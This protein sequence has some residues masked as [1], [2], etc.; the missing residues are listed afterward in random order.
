MVGFNSSQ[1]LQASWAPT[2]Q[3]EPFITYRVIA[4]SGLKLRAEPGLDYNAIK[5]LPY[6]S[7]IS[8]NFVTNVPA[9]IDGKRAPGFCVY[10][11]GRV[12]WVFDQNVEPIKNRVIFRNSQCTL[13]RIVMGIL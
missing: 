10:G 3:S 9:T 13:G 6:N 2:G 8:R 7:I 4:R 1:F 12:G 11:N 5:V